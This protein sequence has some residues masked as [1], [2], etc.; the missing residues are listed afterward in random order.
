MLFIFNLVFTSLAESWLYFYA[1]K[2]QKSHK[3]RMRSV[4]EE[5]GSCQAVVKQSSGSSQAVV[6]QSSDSRQ[7]I[8]RRSL[9]SC[10]AV[11][12]SSLGSCQAFFKQLVDSRNSIR[13]VICFQSCFYKSG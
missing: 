3:M 4:G 13:I 5:S 8:V 2:G 6:R 12:K 7:A 1:G 10:Q 11:V 9:G